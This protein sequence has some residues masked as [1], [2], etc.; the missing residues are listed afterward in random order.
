MAVGFKLPSAV[1][2]YAI[3][4]LILF[5]ETRIGYFDFARG[6]FGLYFPINGNLRVV[7]LPNDFL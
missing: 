6:I 5:A 3:C 7:L 4:L 2:S 1:M